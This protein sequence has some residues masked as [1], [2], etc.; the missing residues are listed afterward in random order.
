MDD[1]PK[2]SNA[3][4]LFPVFHGCNSG[5]DLSFGQF[6][7]K[8]LAD[9]SSL[10]DKVA[11]VDSEV[12][13]D[14]TINR[15]RE[16]VGTELLNEGFEGNGNPNEYGLKLEEIIDNLSHYWE[17]QRKQFKRRGTW[18]WL[19]FLMQYDKNYHYKRD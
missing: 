1:I 12:L 6:L 10:L 19:L 4:D 17:S 15:M 2:S 13:E 9:A 18:F 8:Y 16:A 5:F 14:S 3:M 11:L 7:L